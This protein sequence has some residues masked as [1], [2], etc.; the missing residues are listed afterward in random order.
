M[1]E[2][3][4]AFGRHVGTRWQANIL[5]AFALGS[6]RETGQPH[7]RVEAVDISSAKYGI[8]L[9]VCEG[10]PEGVDEF[11]ARPKGESAA[12]LDAKVVAA[13]CA[14]ARE[15]LSAMASSVAESCKA[16][17]GTTS[18]RTASVLT[19]CGRVGFRYPY[20]PKAGVALGAV[21][22]GLSW[23]SR[24]GKQALDSAREK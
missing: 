13:A 11:R 6:H 12:D 7:R 3:A 17:S 10:R 22:P 5:R 21:V 23:I 14:D 9:G 24:K 8:I 20:A 2:S 19:G 18:H 4:V 16:S 1:S 15:L